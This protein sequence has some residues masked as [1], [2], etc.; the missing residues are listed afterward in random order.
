MLNLYQS[1]IGESSLTSVREQRLTYLTPAEK[2]RKLEAQ[3]RA[4]TKQTVNPAKPTITPPSPTGN[5]KGVITPTIFQGGP[6]TSPIQQKI[7]ASI[8]SATFTPT[9]NTDALGNVWETKQGGAK[10]LIGGG[11]INEKGVR[12]PETSSATARS[13]DPI[14]STQGALSRDATSQI[15]AGYANI[16]KQREA[17]GETAQANVVAP[18]TSFL[19]ESP[20]GVQS[21]LLKN[22]TVQ[23][24]IAS[25]RDRAIS[26]DPR[27][28]DAK[29][30]LLNSSA[31]L[32]SARQNIQTIKQ[33]QE[34]ANLEQEITV[35]NDI[36]ALVEENQK[37]ADERI[38]SFLTPDTLGAIALNPEIAD[39]LLA[40]FEGTSYTTAQIREM[41]YL[42][43]QVNEYAS[44]K[45]L[46]PE[47][48]VKLDQARA[49]LTKTQAEV[50]QIGKTDPT[51]SQ[52][53]FGF[54]QQLQAS[55]PA[56][57]EQFA[58]MKGFGAEAPLS[59]IEQQI[60]EADLAYKNAQ[61]AVQRANARKTLDGLTDYKAYSETNAD[62]VGTLSNLGDSMHTDELYAAAG[63]SR[64]GG[65]EFYG[66]CAAFV[67]DTLGSA[68]KYG[69]NL[70]DK[71]RNINSDTPTPGS[72]FVSNIGAAGI[73][74]CGFVESVDY[75]N[76]TATIYDVNRHGGGQGSRRNISFND[77]ASPTGEGVIGYEN[78]SLTSKENAG[79]AGTATE[80]DRFVSRYELAST[81]SAKDAILAEA[82][83][84]NLGE[85]VAERLADSVVQDPT[86]QN[87][88]AATGLSQ[89]AFMAATGQLSKLPRDAATRNR[90]NKEFETWAKTNDVDTSLI[91]AQYDAYQKTV[92]ANVLRNNQ[93]QV[94]E[95]EVGATLGNLKEA[96]DE[97]SFGD[98]KLKNV[99]KMFAGEQFNDP[100]LSKYSFHLSQLR[101]EFA[102]YNAALSGQIDDN[103][104]IRKINDS[105]HDRAEQIIFD[106]FAEGGIEGF[107][108]ALEASISKMGVILESSISAQ[109]DRVWDIFGVQKPQGGEVDL[110]TFDLEDEGEQASYTETK[111][112]IQG[113]IDA[114]ENDED[115]EQYLIE[116]KIDPNQFL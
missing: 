26:S 14:L 114:G 63:I 98:I 54:Y 101:E 111:N 53:D 76:Q 68:S 49:N 77:L 85:Q 113:L 75:E 82:E 87:I 8:D 51:T 116:L 15:A 45:T 56:M 90:A 37:T 74:H 3:T 4:V 38:T 109:Q 7:D 70:T 62:V 60:K 13:L 99:V 23:S 18:I 12:V 9:Q 55:D 59:S 69:S 41:A 86:S 28:I 22:K 50:A 46:T 48:Q 110:I 80:A 42:Q 71:T 6:T 36:I 112:T 21:G 67:N 108:N 103:G 27:V 2:Q 107:E 30:K 65:Q 83:K 78:L 17:A 16:A 66:Q 29:N 31:K 5:A 84:A 64:T 20:E 94:A 19:Q 47:E 43:G 104:N 106:G 81:P 33:A 10:V 115:I 32:A 100:N 57:A 61:T 96:A 88:L 89:N 34:V 93:S 79:A 102:L 25:A 73:G 11:Y 35:A 95:S 92:T 105:D 24:N 44:K 39:S 52:Q 1:R 72:V 97:A 58:K 40:S 91:G